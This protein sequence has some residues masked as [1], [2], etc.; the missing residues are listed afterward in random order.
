MSTTAFRATKILSTVKVNIPVKL[1]FQSYQNHITP[2]RH[3]ASQQLIGVEVENLG[4]QSYQ[5]PVSDGS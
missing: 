5:N 3:Y 2:G 1:S 4:F